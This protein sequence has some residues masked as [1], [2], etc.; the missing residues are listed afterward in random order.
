[1]RNVTEKKTAEVLQVIE[2]I[3]YSLKYYYYYYH[4]LMSNT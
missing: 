1:M 3:K 2:M 4:G